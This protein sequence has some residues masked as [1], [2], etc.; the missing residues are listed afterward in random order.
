M[1]FQRLAQLIGGSFAP[2]KA[3]IDAEYAR[4]HEQITAAVALI[5]RK[6]HEN[7]TVTD[8]EVQ[9]YYDDEKAKGAAKTDD[10]APPAQADPILLSKEKRTVKYVL[11]TRP[12]P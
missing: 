11:T 7:Q 4:I 12:K 1:L 8:E 3:E 9:K 2:S 6:N 10:K 5:D